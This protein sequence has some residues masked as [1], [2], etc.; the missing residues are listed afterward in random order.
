M[1]KWWKHDIIRCDSTVT[2]GFDS[3]TCTESPFLQDVPIDLGI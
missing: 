1:N 3:F 2:V